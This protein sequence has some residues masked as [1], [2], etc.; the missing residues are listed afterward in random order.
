MSS[1]QLVS[2]HDRRIQAAFWYGLVAFLIT[3]YLLYYAAQA[4]TPPKWAVMT[5]NML[6]PTLKAL[7]TA[8]R[9]S[10][11]PFPAQ[12]VIVYCAVGS[13]TLTAWLTYWLFIIE[14]SREIC[15]HKALAQ[16]IS[17][18]KLSLTA[19]TMPLLLLLFI[20]LLVDEPTHIDWRD[21][22]YFSPRLSSVTL[23]LVTYV[24]A[25]LTIPATLCTLWSAVIVEE[26]Q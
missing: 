8:A 24:T 16:N 26:N 20:W 17:R 4:V 18:M 21:V 11:T 5:I 15:R 6:K 19:A 2:A 12:V 22:S 7:S 13:V 10:E 1:D 9:I 25:S 3:G 14:E 23:L